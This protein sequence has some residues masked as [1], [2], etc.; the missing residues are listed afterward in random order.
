MRRLLFFLTPI[1]SCSLAMGQYVFMAGDTDKTI[2]LRVEDSSVSTGAGLTGIAYDAA[3]LGCY[4]KR[5][6]TADTV[7]LTLATLATEETAHSDGGWIQVD[8]TNAPGVYRL[9]LSDAVIA[10][11]VANV[12]IHCDGATNM[13]QTTAVIRLVGYDPEDAGLGAG[14]ATP[15][16]EVR[17]TVVPTN[18]TTEIQWRWYTNNA[19]E[20][21][22]TAN[23]IWCST[24][25]ATN[26][27][28]IGT[29]GAPTAAGGE[30]GS[31]D[32]F[33][34]SSTADMVLNTPYACR[35]QATIA[36]STRTD[37]FLTTKTSTG[38]TVDGGFN[39]F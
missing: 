39:P 3:G 36:S 8:A 11:G 30:A 25:D 16:Y 2:F 13:R 9:D 23:T 37:W 12:M 5:G 33:Y 17:A 32:T 21:S 22:A 15:V 6:A 7:I 19:V 10:A 26:S 14:L 4:Y 1:L 27:N 38:T 24:A 20:G 31:T 29:S 35:V 18:T 28:F 34:L